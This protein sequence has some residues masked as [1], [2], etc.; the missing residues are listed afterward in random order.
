MILYSIHRAKNQGL[1]DREVCIKA[2]IDEQLPMRWKVKYG[3]YFIDWLEEAIDQEGGDDAAVLERVGMMQAVQGGN[4]QYWREMARTKGVIKD[5][6]PKAS[7]TINTDFT[8]IMQATGGNLDAA[9]QQLLSAARGLAI[10]D[11]SRVVIPIVI[12]NEQGKHSGEGAGASPLQARPVEMANALGTDRGRPEQG[13]P[14][15]AVPQQATF[16]GSYAILDEGEVS[17]SPEESPDDLH[18]AF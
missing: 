17:S 4:F 7:L 12:G 9:R 16:A 14:I 2:G 13:A 15:P 6:L 18:L 3:T 1:S 11:G 10:P 5:E 8:V